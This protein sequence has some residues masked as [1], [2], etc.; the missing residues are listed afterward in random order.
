V[1]SWI[2]EPWG[3]VA[4]H[5]DKQAVQTIAACM[6]A[7]RPSGAGD[8]LQRSFAQY[9]AMI[10][11]VRHA[12]GFINRARY[13]R[14]LLILPPWK[15]AREYRTTN[16]LLLPFLYFIHP[17]VRLSQ[18]FRGTLRNVQRRLGH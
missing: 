15:M 13:L 4:G 16:R 12:D 9:M 17:L 3:G 6:N 2:G 1:F 14:D 5:G 11:G 18:G 10:K 7:A 8:P